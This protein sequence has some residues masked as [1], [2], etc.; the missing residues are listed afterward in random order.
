MTT[1]T[2]RMRLHYN[3][4]DN[5]TSIGVYILKRLP[6]TSHIFSVSIDKYFGYL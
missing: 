3:A 4:I 6:P 2:D 5:G 1:V